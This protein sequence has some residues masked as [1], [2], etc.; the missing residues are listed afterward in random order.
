MEGVHQDRF[1]PGE[2]WQVGRWGHDLYQNMIFGGAWASRLRAAMTDAD[3]NP[4]EIH[5][6]FEVPADGVYKV[7]VK[8]ECPPH[9]NYAFGV[10]IE[11]LGPAGPA[12]FNRV[13]GL[14][15]SAKHYCFNDKPH[16]GDLYWNWGIDHDA[17]EGY[18]A[19][20]AK[21]RYRITL[22][23]MDNPGPKGA[24]SIDAIL[25]TSDLSDISAPHLPRY[26]LLD[27]LRR[28]NHVYFRFRNPPQ[29][30][31]PIFI[32]WNHWNH[33]YPDFYQPAYR[34]LVEFYDEHG[35]RLTG[36]KNGDWPGGIAPGSAGPWYDLGP[37]MNTE[38]SSPY[39]IAAHPKDAAPD[40]ASLPFDVDIALAPNAKAIVK[41]FTCE[42]GEKA[43]AILV[44][45]DLHRPEGVAHTKTIREIC[46]ELTRELD[47]QPR[48]GPLPRKIRLFGASGGIT[49]HGVLADEVG[50]HMALR[51][52]MGLNTFPI[53]TDPRVVPAILAWARD[54]GGIIERSLCY[55][56]SQDPQEISNWV[57]KGGVEKQFYYLS[58]GDEIGLPATDANDS[59]AV[60]AFREFLRNRG[61]SPQGLGLAGWD[62]V[63]P[64]AALSGDVAV[65]I[66]VL[67]DAG[68]ADAAG[69]AGLKRL[70]WHSLAFRTEQGIAS[71]AEKTRTLRAAL[72]NEV[73]TSANLGSMH[74]FY[75][76]HQSSFIE[77]FKHQA[78]SLAWSE[79]YTFCQPEASRLVADLEAAYLRKGA[80]YHDTPMQFYCMPHWPGNNPDQLIQNA[81]LEWGQNVKDLDFFSA[82]PDTWSTENYVAY[83]GGLPTLRAIRTISGMAGAVEDYL[84]PARTEPAPVAMLLSETS[85][86]WETEGKGQGAVE[87]GSAASNVSQEERKNLW[88]CL[89]YAGYRIDPVT[90]ADCADGLLKNYSALYVCGQNLH[91]QAAAAIRSWVEA[92]GIVF[93]TA[94]AARKDEADAPL[95]ALDEVLGRSGQTAYQRY[96]GPLRARIELMFLP[97]LD[98]IGLTDGSAVAVYGSREQFQVGPEAEVLGSYKDGKPGWI[99]RRFG[100]G[101]GYYCGA[102]PG[103]A[104]VKAALPTTPPGKGGPPGRPA[105]TE[106]LGH[107]PAAAAMILRP[108]EE[109]KIRP[110][111]VVDHRGVV[112]NRLKAEGATILT[113]VNLALQADGPLKN[114]EIQVRN[115]RPVQ[116]AWSCFHPKGPLLKGADDRSVVLRLPAIGPADVVVLQH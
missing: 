40:S 101:R 80:A 100:K 61:E 104:F 71:F 36:G 62:Q 74:P 77:A 89:R 30:A 2:G 50:V 17:A 9:F 64:L 82:T 41:T 66:G 21:G 111:V 18:D 4:A 38:S 55:H 54:H 68:K 44:Q 76:M 107:D 35:K 26:P 85:D 70:Y 114:V 106:H 78:M 57:R 86:V 5:A 58:F 12:V 95:T 75:W 10:R 47:R 97:A 19:R 52:A 23:K 93:A 103:Q 34:E 7:W 25:I 110:D 42:P 33:R 73:H 90:E 72:G 92:G 116:R 1:G 115:V 94:G 20:L 51:E 81:V 113:V 91:R 49:S 108:L 24:R 48:L 105:M 88:Y 15:Q 56:H 98:E 3:G 29:A 65:R 43:L 109:A 112:T 39:L 28:A 60:E 84:V 6:D 79:D 96:R 31:A 32:T 8:Y 11:P 83:R 13:Y 67:P 69:I 102:L 45:P 59:R 16:Q 14:R 87:P 37:T 27:E 63:K 53:N 46:G 99:T 22:S